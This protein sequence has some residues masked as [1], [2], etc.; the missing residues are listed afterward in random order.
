MMFVLFVHCHVCPSRQ[1]A[2][3]VP[4]GAFPSTKPSLAGA[5]RG[6]GSGGG[7]VIGLYIHLLA[8]WG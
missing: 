2:G 3:R 6:A 5:R 4:E 8:L 1:L 7:C